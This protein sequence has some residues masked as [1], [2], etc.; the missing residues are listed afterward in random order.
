MS[1][2]VLLSDVGNPDHGQDPT[3]SLTGRRPRRI[4]VKD[5]AE[6]SK[7]CRAYIEQHELGAGN[8]S[9]GKVFEDGREIAEV[10][11]N[12]RVWALPRRM[13]QTPL[14]PEPVGPEAA[15]QPTD[16]VEPLV[17]DSAVVEVPGH[18]EVKVSGCYRVAHCESVGDFMVGRE[19]CQFS[20]YISVDRDGVRYIEDF[21]LYVGGEY[22]RPKTPSSG[23]RGLLLAAL[24]NFAATP[25]GATLFLRNQHKDELHDLQVM[26]RNIRHDERELERKRAE[27][28]AKRSAVEALAAEVEA[29]APSAK[30]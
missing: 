5:Y 23:L 17:W 1:L 8:W 19:A 20:T 24:Q 21:N 30:P 29:S 15:S 12:G 6:A 18:G 13:D 25:E 4:K 22:G 3:R 28:A 27:A 16:G 10:S 11:Y 26:E 7:V 9:G 14:W 2:E